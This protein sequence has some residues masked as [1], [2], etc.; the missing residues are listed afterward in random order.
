MALNMP[1]FA[2]P[3]QRS[4][5]EEAFGLALATIARNLIN[6]PFEVQAEKRAA[7]QRE[8]EMVLSTDQNIRQGSAMAKIGLENWAATNLVPLTS[9]LETALKGVDVTPGAAS[10][11]GKGF[12]LP[13][14]RYIGRDLAVQATQGAAPAAPNAARQSIYDLVKS[15][16]GD[17]A[18]GITA[19]GRAVTPSTLKTTPQSN[20]Q[21][22]QS[23]KL[24]GELVSAGSMYEQ[25]QFRKDNA[26]AT[27]ATRLDQLI[28]NITDDDIASFG[29]LYIDGEGPATFEDIQAMKGGQRLENA[30]PALYEKWQHWNDMIKA[31]KV[32]RISLTKKAMED[33]REHVQGANGAQALLQL[34]QIAAQT[35]VLVDP[36]TGKNYTDMQN[37]K[38]VAD[39]IRGNPDLLDAILAFRATAGVE[40]VMIA[41][42]S[43]NG[44]QLT[45]GSKAILQKMWA[46]SG[47]RELFP[48]LEPGGEGKNAE[49]TDPDDPD[50]P[51]YNTPATDSTEVAASP[52]RYPGGAPEAIVRDTSKLVGGLLS[53]V[54]RAMS[55]QS[56]TYTKRD[57][58][59]TVKTSAGFSG[60]AAAAESGVEK[61]AYDF[62]YGAL[63]TNG[64][65]M[66]PTYEKFVTDNFKDAATAASFMREHGWA[67]A[68]L[69][70]GN[71]QVKSLRLAM[72]KNRYNRALQNARDARVA[73]ERP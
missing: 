2:Q 73:D 44:A 37:A 66:L 46:A 35:G 10:Y 28:G 13:G 48:E 53:G 54:G 7:I 71:A 27:R 19:S 45:P 56:A 21:A 15:V 3:K 16:V 42:R 59:P 67:D 69:E 41:E 55:G 20:Y 68:E 36:K 62:F 50:N 24:M 43:Q 57:S 70:S 61:Q 5:I 18:P 40:D 31:G 58:I 32:K 6:K 47:K 8:K 25:D 34:G 52:N 4:V 51:D 60:T 22:A 23:D 38:H 65:K 64:L 33:A 63:K 17:A 14:E 9:E 12:G 26:A 29:S 30:A 1:S 11:K 72:L 39:I 49:I